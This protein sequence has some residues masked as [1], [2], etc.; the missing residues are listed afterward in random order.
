MPVIPQHL[1]P[2]LQIVLNVFDQLP[3]DRKSQHISEI[4]RKYKHWPCIQDDMEQ[5][6]NT[7]LNRLT[8]QQSNQV[9]PKQCDESTVKSLSMCPELMI[10]GILILCCS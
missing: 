10:G 4:Y 8:S 6:V 3:L 9:C 1:S 2:S 5:R 7:V